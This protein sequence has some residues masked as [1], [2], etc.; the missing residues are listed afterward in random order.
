MQP[1][2]TGSSFWRRPE[3]RNFFDMKQP[4]VYMLASKRNGTLYVGVT[5]NL[6]GRVWL[7][8]NDV[9][10]G[11]TSRYGV[12]L[13]VWFEMHPTMLSAIVREK[14]LKFWKRAWKMRLIES[15]NPKWRDLYPEI[16]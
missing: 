6:R 7:H 11:F 5:S 12:H 14:A 2:V 9:A 13:L 8:K 4:C 3:S 10:E 16:L 15:S 1:V